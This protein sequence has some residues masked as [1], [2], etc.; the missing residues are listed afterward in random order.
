[1]AGQNEDGCKNTPLL[2]D[3]DRQGLVC[4]NIGAHECTHRF[5]AMGTGSEHACRQHPAKLSSNWS[6]PPRKDTQ[7][8]SPQM[9]S[10]T[11]THNDK[12]S[13]EPTDAG[14]RQLLL[15]SIFAAARGCR[16]GPY[17]PLPEPTHR[18]FL[19]SCSVRVQNT[20]RCVSQ[21]RHPEMESF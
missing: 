4:H 13:T 17:C 11:R 7:R 1:M 5:E 14:P 2:L 9:R 12:H 8:A 10:T 18:G 21:K 20:C 6:R 16:C 15:A 3:R 19:T